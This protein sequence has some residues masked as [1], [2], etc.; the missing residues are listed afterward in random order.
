MP[1]GLVIR[2]GSVRVRIFASRSGKYLRHEIRW[3][4]HHGRR[5]RQK[6]SNATAARREAQRIADDLARGHH[7]SELTLADLASFRAAI[8]N[9]YG[10]GKT[11]E[12]ATAEYAGVVRK[13]REAR[14]GQL[15]PSFEEL[16]TFWLEN[17]NTTLATLTVTAAVEQ[18]LQVKTAQGISARWHGALK[19]Q[20][21]RFSRAHP[22]QMSALKA[23]DVRQWAYALPVGPRARNNHLAAVKLLFNLG[24]LRA[25]R[26]RQAVLDIPTITIEA[27][28]N[29]L[30]TPGEFTR[31]LNAAPAHL[32]PVLV[33]GGFGKLRSSEIM[34]IEIANLK[35]KEK[36]VLLHAGQ[37]K[38]RRWR[39]VPLPACAVAWLRH[40]GLKA[41]GR[42]WPWGTQKFNADLRALATA[43]GLEWRPNALRNS[44]I[45]YDQICR[46]DVARVAREA[47]NSA[48]VVETEYLALNGITRATAKAW[49]RILPPR[50]KRV[51]VPMA[52]A[53]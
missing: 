39:I 26:E 35:L 13:L 11:L 12:L 2:S 51:I 25:H 47:G 7:H 48:S 32:L 23:A 33:L 8:V 5:R 22:V 24:E 46:P 41:N 42:L 6:I 20:L 18:L 16:A 34:R 44:A 14:P 17:Q 27:P 37:T 1:K 4:D 50:Q 15:M 52:V 38:T 36:R 31:L 10:C 30:W 53:K 28:A 29:A 3:T 49:F 40:A 45:T 21:R 9:L 19:S 43:C